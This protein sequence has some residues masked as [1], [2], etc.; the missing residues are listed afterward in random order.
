MFGERLFEF[1]K[2][3]QMTQRQLANAIGVDFTYISKIESGG[4]PPPARDKIEL[5]AKTLKLSPIESDELFRLAGKLP[6]GVAAFMTREPSA[7]RLLR[8]IRQVP[9]A[10][11]ERLI[12]H[13]I[14]EAERRH[15]K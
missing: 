10:E 13:L 9:V 1:R 7:Q 5:L 2:R 14:R 3:V 11:Q 4:A 6:E 12:E 15:R 8:S